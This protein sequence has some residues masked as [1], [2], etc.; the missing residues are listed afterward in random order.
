LSVLETKDPQIEV[1]V[2]YDAS[3]VKSLQL[4]KALAATHANAIKLYCQSINGGP[5]KARNA[6]AARAKGKYLFFLDSD[7]EMEPYSIKNFRHRILGAD[8]VIGIYDKIPLII[9][10]S[11]PS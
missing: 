7:T 1:I 6:G 8:A 10:A 2:V 9:K 11:I 4:V 5:A 3:T